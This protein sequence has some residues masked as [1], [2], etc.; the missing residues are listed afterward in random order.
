M[1]IQDKQGSVVNALIAAGMNFLLT[2]PNAAPT[3]PPTIVLA[4]PLNGR[5]CLVYWDGATY[6][7]TLS[8]EQCRAVEHWPL[9]AEE[10]S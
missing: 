3:N 8:I 4:D 1:N 9:T 10:A 5:V 6:D 7:S 2:R